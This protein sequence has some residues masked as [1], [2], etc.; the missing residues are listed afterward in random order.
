MSKPKAGTL[1]AAMAAMLLA[2]AVSAC[3][4]PGRPP[5]VPAGPVPW[6]AAIGR[7]DVVSGSCTATLVEPDIILT[8]AHCLFT[9]GKKLS[10]DSLTFT[11]NFGGQ[12]L[13][14][15]RVAAVVAIGVDQMN[16]DDDEDQT[17]RENDWAILRLAEPITSIAPIPVQAMDLDEIERRQKAGETLSTLGYGS[18]GIS[19][20]RHLNRVDGCTLVPEWRSLIGENGKLMVITT[21]P[22]T[23]VIKGDSGGAIVITDQ[24]EQ[25]RLVAVISGYWIRRTGP[26]SLAVSAAAFDE[27]L[28]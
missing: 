19:T 12:R 13:P 14:A 4:T 15:A 24:T 9:E 1:L 18:Y 20:S 26:V 22:L 28:K 7:L 2:C 21:C 11:P 25:R 17:P 16:P 23:P 5:A 27:A 10:P 3:D 6:T 8:A